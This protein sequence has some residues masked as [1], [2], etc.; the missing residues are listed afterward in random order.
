MKNLH[1]KL[2][3]EEWRT[4]FQAMT[5]GERKAM[6]DSVIDIEKMQILDLD[7]PRSIEHVLSN[8]LELEMEV[9]Q[10]AKRLRMAYERASDG[11][12]DQFFEDPFDGFID[13]QC[14]PF[15]G[16]FKGN[17]AVLTVGPSGRIGRDL[18]RVLLVCQ[19]HTSA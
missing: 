18:F 5:L 4:G 16:P 12:L 3:E 11:R 1:R 13:F 2:T 6:R 14:P 19:K 7:D 17:L 10:N 9:K 15:S 8:W